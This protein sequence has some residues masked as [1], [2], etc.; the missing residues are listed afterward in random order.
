MTS[1]VLVFL[2]KKASSARR[3]FLRKAIVQGRSR[4][5]VVTP[6]YGSFRPSKLDTVAGSA[7]RIFLCE[8]V[9]QGRS[10]THHVHVNASLAHLP[11]AGQQ[12]TPVVA[13][14]RRGSCRSVGQVLGEWNR[15][16]IVVRVVGVRIVCGFAVVD[17]LYVHLELLGSS[18][19]GVSKVCVGHF[20][21]GGVGGISGRWGR[22]FSVC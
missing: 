11:L 4:S 3:I 2:K 1:S 7:R 20:T 10:K 12:V 6:T 21:G 22:H 17:S 9:V 15:T 8:M 18:E 14:V 19:L 13:V 16:S 5:S